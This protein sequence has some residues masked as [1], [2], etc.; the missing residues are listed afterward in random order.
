ME[1]DDQLLQELAD[2]RSK[3]REL[4]ARVPTVDRA[5][6]RRDRRLTIA[7]VLVVVLTMGFVG[8][9]AA[10][11]LP[12][13]DSVFSDDIRDNA[14]KARHI[15]DGAV[16][17]D[18]IANGQVRGPDLGLASD[19][20]CGTE[21]VHSWAL[22]ELNPDMPHNT[23]L[24]GPTVLPGAYNCSGQKVQL[25]SK[26]HGNFCIRFLG[27]PAWLAVSNGA[28]YEGN[29]ADADI[30]EIDLGPRDAAFCKGTGGFPLRVFEYTPYESAPSYYRPVS[31]GSVVVTTF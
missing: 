20:H 27:D 5:S 25:M 29:G 13:S 14:V 17:S 12:G 15:A 8:I 7:Y 18:D 22:I 26:N 28:F 11:A 31:Y 6:K 4:Q 2:L 9:G 1:R 21:Q 23:W 3:V 10:T 30:L 19:N 16:R 24:G